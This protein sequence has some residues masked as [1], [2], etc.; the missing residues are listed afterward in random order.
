MLISYDGSWGIAEDGDEVWRG[1]GL[2]KGAILVLVGG[3]VEANGMV[4]A[5]TLV[6]VERLGLWELR[7]GG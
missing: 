3:R 6:L 2:G 4:M 7:R 1:S 5:G